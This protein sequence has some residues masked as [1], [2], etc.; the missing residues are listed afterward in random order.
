M[1]DAWPSRMRL[2]IDA[3]VLWQISGGPDP[4]P[5]W[6][7]PGGT[8]RDRPA[9]RG[10]PGRVFPGGSGTRSCR[11]HC[12]ASGRDDRQRRPLRLIAT[13]GSNRYSRTARVDRRVR[14]THFLAP[15]P[16]RRRRGESHGRCRCRI[17]GK[18]QDHQ[19]LSGAGLHGSGVLRPCARP[20]RQG[21]FGRSHER[22]R[23]D[24]GGR[25]EGPAPCPRHRR[26]AEGRQPADPRNRP[27][28]RGRGDLV[29]PAGGA[30]QAAC[31][32]E[33][34]R[35]PARRFQR[36]HAPRRHRGDGESA[37]HRHGT[38]RGLPG[39]PGAG[40]SGRFH[41]VAGA[42]AQIAGRALGRAGA[43]GDAAP[44]RRAR[45]GDRS[46]PQ[47]RILVGQGDPDHAGG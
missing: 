1:V 21:R 5:A 29:A 27:G 4:P 40:I 37:R 24:L 38:G 42:V 18:S 46:L 17:P 39:A 44:G 11:P 45:D 2:L 28:P 36:H 34:H 10:I 41:P 47:P 35:G 25:P 14:L 3:S 31:G 12:A 22:A 19:R 15:R 30:A 26:G 20:A 13:P 33:D 43:I 8:R 9:M 32:E 23:N 6:P 7:A 16:S